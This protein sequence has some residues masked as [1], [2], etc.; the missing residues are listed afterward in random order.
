MRKTSRFGNAASIVAVSALLIGAASQAKAIVTISIGDAQGTQGDTVAVSVGLM[1]GTASVAGTENE[2]HFPLEAQIAGTQVGE[3]VV[4]DCAVNPAIGKEATGFTFLPNGCTPGTD[5]TGVKAIV[6]SISNLSAIPDGSVLYTCQVAIAADAADGDYTL[7]CANPGASD[8][9]GV[10]LE[11]DCVDGTVT[12]GAPPLTETPTA[13]ETLPVA[14][15]DTPTATPTPTAV[16]SDEAVIVV[17]SVEASPGETVPVDVTLFVGAD[18]QDPGVGG[19]QSDISFG[20]GIS[21]VANESERPDCTVNPDINKEA[22]AFSFVTEDDGSTAVRALV[23]SLSNVDPIPSGSVLFTCNVAVDEGANNDFPLTCSRALASTTGGDPIENTVCTDGSVDVPEFVSADLEAGGELTTDTEGDGCTDIDVVETTL[24]SPNAGMASIDERGPRGSAPTG[25][26]FVGLQSTVEAPDASA[27]DPL[28]IE[29][30]IDASQVTEGATVAIFKDGV[31]VEDCADT[32]GTANPDPCISEQSVGDDGD[33][34]I[35]IISST[36]SVWT[37]GEPAE[38]PAT[39]TPTMTA[40]PSGPTETPSGPTSTPTV[41]ATETPVVPPTATR[42]PF[43]EDDGCQIV[44]PA[45]GSLA[46]LL[47]LPVGM[48]LWRRRRSR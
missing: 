10:A 28:V 33:V 44:A 41:G 36:A 13:T 46:W 3:N 40:T 35:T 20:P 29:F 27:D 8:P 32:S 21:I 12:V 24:T 37:F 11:T 9:D 14:P 26:T 6:L 2:I 18:L 23:L 5:C 25:F 7:A 45:D 1:V 22:S 47:L 39:P 34:N 15:T 19:T 38:M 42:P 48:L 43:D 31:Q 17:G 30:C 4:P 16:A